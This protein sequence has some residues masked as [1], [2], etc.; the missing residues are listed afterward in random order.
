[1]RL[2]TW[3]ERNFFVFLG[4]DY[5]GKMMGANVVI[6]VAVEVVVLVWWR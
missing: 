4:R 1:M 5:L 3:C 6:E 2:W